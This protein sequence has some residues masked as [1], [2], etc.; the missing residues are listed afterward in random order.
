[1]GKTIYTIRKREL[2]DTTRASI[3]GDFVKLSNGYTYYELKGDKDAKTIVLVHGNAAPSFTWDY[4]VQPLVDRGFRV[5]R[6]DIYGH[7]YSDRPK[8]ETYNKSLYDQQLIELLEKLNIKE[9]VYL[10]GTSQGG[11]ICAYFTAKHPELVEKIAFLSPLFDKFEGEDKVKIMKSK[12]GEE[13][14]NQMGDEMLLDPSNVFYSN[15][16][17]EELSKKLKNQLMY[18]GKKRAIL[19][20]IRGD[21]LDDATIYYEKV[22]NQN[23]PMLLTWGEYDRSISKESMDRLRKLIPNMKFK[24]IRNASHLVHYEFPDKIN[25]IIID[26]LTKDN[27]NNM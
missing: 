17:K 10:V 25:P 2:N 13:L 22:K 3:K 15:D 1:M 16:K 9:S 14:M 21:G 4:N 24:L 7:G 18:K 23:I 8:L 12:K 11:S 27:T 19:A 20:N 26:F 6:Y 5:L